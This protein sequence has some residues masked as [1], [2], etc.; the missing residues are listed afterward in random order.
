PAPDAAEGAKVRQMVRD[1]R[2]WA[3]ANYDPYRVEDERWVG[4]E[5]IRALGEMG[6]LGLYV[7]PEYGGQGLSQTGYARVFEEIGQ[8]DATLAIVLGVHQSIGF[9]GISLFGTDDQKAR[10]LPD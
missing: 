1:L 3:G 10:W 8:I 2:D 9:K 4:D 6:F 5:T 7:E